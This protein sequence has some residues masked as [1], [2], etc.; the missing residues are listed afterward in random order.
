MIA[1]EPPRPADERLRLG[2]SACLLGHETRYDGGHKLDRF[3]VDELG[4]FV[5]FV[6]V[7]PE[8]ECG[9]P[10]PREAM[11]L[12]GEPESP[13]LMTVR[14]NVDLTDQM[15]TWVRRRVEELA[16]ENL[17]GFIFKTKSP[18]SG[19]RGVKVYNDKGVPSKKGTGL[20]ARAFMERFPLIPVEDDGRLHDAG[21]RENFVERVFSLKRWR[22]TLASGR[23]VHAL[24]EFHTRH[25]YLLHAHS[26]THA[27]ALGKLVASAKAREIPEV[28]AEYEATLLDALAR[29]ATVRKHCNAL[30]HMLGYFKRQI[31]ADEKQEMLEIVEQYRA[32]HAPLLVPMTLMN[33]YVR[34][35]DQP[36][37]KKQV[38]LNPHPVELR[39]RAYC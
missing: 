24:V 8:V 37:L 16:K 20:F 36:Y 25:K 3:I 5:D 30:Q 39:L 10:V 29:K 11:R 21:L 27:R 33:H 4:R 2:A 31:T 14:T 34:K 17:C 32:G 9:L 26:E 18:S 38:Y 13:R 35:Y 15:M 6:P 19:M 23:T 12:V 22:D 28:F 1:T 7:C